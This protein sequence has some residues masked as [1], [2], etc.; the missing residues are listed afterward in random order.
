MTPET[1]WTLHWH[2][3]TAWEAML[4]A[5]DGA[6]KTIRF[7]QFS[8]ESFKEGE[9]G[10][11]FVELFVRKARQGVKVRLLVDSIGSTELLR[12]SMVAMMGQAGVEVEWNTVGAPWRPLRFLLH[13][14]RNHR[15]LVVVDHEVA[16]VG[17]VIVNERARNWRDTQIELRGRIVQELK[18]AFDDLWYS[19]R[20]GDES[21]LDVPG[22]RQNGFEVA[23][24]TP[25]ITH[26]RIRN[27]LVGKIRR[28]RKR[29]WITVPYFSP[30]RGLLRMLKRAVR[31]GVDTR[32]LLPKNSDQLAAD[33]AARS[34]FTSLLRSKIRI[35][36]YEG[37][38][39]HA[40]T[41]IVDHAWA[42]IGSAN[43]DP[44]SLYYNHELNL[45]TIRSDVVAA[46]REQFLKDLESA[47][48]ISLQQ[49][50]LRP[51][52]EKMLEATVGMMLRKVV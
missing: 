17:G 28:A 14:V 46:L 20:G 16:F 15:K 27:D 21:L 26:R 6:K 8:F 40:K 37:E 31:R 50:R 49:W 23:V 52:Y 3:H 33:L 18:V 1:R 4:A 32:I 45:H 19:V 35:F 10:R 22:E 36:L 42:T 5:C 48:E 41:A 25:G 12:S 43:L 13:L 34:Y 2:S 7:E 38:V 30:D 24:N 44:L 29:I 47:E 11:R 39:L 9:I 51:W